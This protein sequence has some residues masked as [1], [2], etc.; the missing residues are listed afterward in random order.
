MRLA[1][2]FAL[3]FAFTAAFTAAAAASAAER[4]G[5][6]RFFDQEDG[7]LDFSEFL[8][9]PRGFLPIPILITEPAVGYGG[10]AVGM[11]LRPRREAGDEGWARPNMSAVGAFATQNGTWGAFAGDSSRWLDG[12]LRTLAGVG[13]GMVNLDFHGLGNSAFTFPEKV[14]YSLDFTAVIAQASWQLAPKSPWAVGLRYVHAEV[15]PKLRDDPAFPGLT[16]RIRVKVAAP[17][18]VLEYDSRD[19]MFTPTRGIYAETT[20]LASRE[21]LGAT[22]DFNRFQQVLIGWYPLRKDV[23]LAARANYARASDATPFFLRPY[24]ELRGVPAARY[25]G[26][27]AGSVEV[28][29]RWQFHG[30][31][32]VVA[33][34]GA[35]RASNHRGSIDDTQTVG[36]GGFGFRYELARKFGLHA[37]IDVARAGS[38]NALYFQVGNAWFRP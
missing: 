3:A 34:G 19:N 31:W 13:T 22:Q 11:F 33:F 15:L 12:R 32:S 29:G 30:R 4:E 8:A 35:G 9:T 24:V 2:A 18:P 1:F 6:A 14:R 5:F 37:G 38:T 27:R 23:T 16:D 17:T 26:E 7:Q 25:Q 28:E 36:G 21:A 10:G 20:Y